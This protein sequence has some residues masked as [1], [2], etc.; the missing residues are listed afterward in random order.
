MAF[1]LSGRGRTAIHGKSSTKKQTEKEKK[2]GKKVGG[3]L[4][5]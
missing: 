5:A 4:G 2:G 3:G 1:G